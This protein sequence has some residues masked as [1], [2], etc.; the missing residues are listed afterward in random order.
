[1]RRNRLIRLLLILLPAAASAPA[2][3]GDWLQFGYDA[4]HSSSNPQGGYTL[5]SGNAFVTG[6]SATGVALSSSTDSSPVLAT[7]IVTASGTKDLL[8]IEAKNGTLLALDASNGAQVWSQRPNTQLAPPSSGLASLSTGSP[9]IDAAKQYIYHYG[10]DGAIHKYAIGT[11]VE[12]TGSGWP[13][14]STYK[15]EVE[16][17]AGA[18]S[19]AS[20]P[21]GTFLYSITDG[22]V[23]DAGDYQGHLTTINL[24]TGTQKVFNSLCSNLA[25]HFIKNGTT[26]GGGQNDCSSRQNG[27]WGR[28]GAIYDAGTNRVF[29]STGNG[30][31]NASTGG[32]NWGDSV[33]A[34][35]PDGSGNGTP[36]MPVDS[37]TPTT[38]QNLQN[39]DADLGSVSVA[40]VPAPAGTAASYQHLGVQ[41]GKDGCVRLINLADMSGNAAPAHT[42]GELSAL[43]LPGGSNCA[44]GGD[45]PEIKPQPAVW[46]NPSDGSTWIYVVSYANGMA[47]YKIVLDG[48][49]VPSLA[50]QWA[51]T[52]MQ[53]G[54][55]TSPVISGGQMYYFSGGRVVVRDALTGA[56]IWT[57]SAL[58]SIHWQ[59]LIVQNGRIYA[60]DG[61]SKLIEWQLDGIF[62]SPFE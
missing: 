31:Y 6:F 14:L 23:G 29:I 59:S 25:I 46:V 40:L 34:L 3:A 54:S 45:S 27:I 49:G 32:F 9:A 26:S 18:L 42:G 56:S 30:P 58:S 5:P 22:Y 4:A 15:P 33:L 8:F 55:G 35:N 60:I 36:G 47:S 12:V 37:Y 39:T 53:G 62:R 21:S 2:C 61:A 24:A 19:I 20:T 41:P 16:K 44:S 7:G 57:S 11:G 1:M 17:G 43:N 52:D 10:N 13:E 38:F 48:S 28:P 50:Q 51:V